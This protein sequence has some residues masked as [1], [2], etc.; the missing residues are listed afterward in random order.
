LLFLSKD[1][2]FVILLLFNSD[3]YDIGLDVSFGGNGIPRIAHDSKGLSNVVVVMLSLVI[4]VIIVVNVVIWGY[5]MNQFDLERMREDVKITGVAYVNGSSPFVN[6]TF[7]NDGSFTSHLVALWVD[8]STT[9]QRYDV[10]IFVNAGDTV[11]YFSADVSLP[12]KPYTV[13]IVTERGNVAVY[14]PS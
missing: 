13:K 1:L 9:H 4:L 5:Q 8:N 2:G 11:T 3:R 7:E 10:S 12:E 14:S 6:F